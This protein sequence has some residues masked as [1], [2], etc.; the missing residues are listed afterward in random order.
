[1]DARPARGRG[2]MGFFLAGQAAS[3]DKCGQYFP[4]AAAF[5]LRGGVSRPA[6]SAALSIAAAAQARVTER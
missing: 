5:R 4:V 3:V 6:P 1:M 2:I